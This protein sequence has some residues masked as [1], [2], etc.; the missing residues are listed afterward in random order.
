MAYQQYRD[1]DWNK[2]R[3]II[4]DL[5]YSEARTYG[6]TASILKS[7]YGFR[8]KSGWIQDRVTRKWKGGKN[9]TK[10]RTKH[11]LESDAYETPSLDLSSGTR[12]MRSAIRH[13]LRVSASHLHCLAIIRDQYLTPSPLDSHKQVLFSS[14]STYVT[15]AFDNQEWKTETFSN[16]IIDDF[17]QW[18]FDN[19]PGVFKTFAFL[20]CATLCCQLGMHVGAQLLLESGLKELP[21]YL[22]AYSPEALLTLIVLLGFFSDR[23][24]TERKKLLD[25]CIST[26]EEANPLGVVLRRIRDAE[27]AE[28][29][30][31]QS[32]DSDFRA[33]LLHNVATIFCNKL[34]DR[35]GPDKLG[36]AIL[37]PLHVTGE[38]E[39]FESLAW[40]DPG[41]VQKK[42]QKFFNS[43][44]NIK[45]FIVLAVE[46]FGVRELLQIEDTLKRQRTA[47]P[48][49][50]VSGLFR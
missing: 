44:L 34:R 10:K 14:V 6:Q 36:Y 17:E 46:R 18:T 39:D 49:D 2:M 29:A 41:L 30:E 35:L 13:N 42:D 3:P 1:D 8:V 31:H 16:G 26:V 23:M 12:M 11:Y 50:R 5:L 47:N 37:Q 9:F 25:Y 27:H 22:N 4:E 19:P 43:D 33:S 48:E 15:G 20:I 21:T 28:H 24:P 40:D 7:H 45:R 38:K 32:P